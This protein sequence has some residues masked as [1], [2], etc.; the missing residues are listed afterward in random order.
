MTSSSC[1]TQETVATEVERQ[2]DPNIVL[3]DSDEYSGIYESTTMVIE[4]AKSL[5]AFYAKINRTRKP[6]LPVP[7]IDFSKNT[8]LVV[9]AGERKPN[10]KMVLSYGDEND[11]TLIINAE[12]YYPNVKED[13]QI[14]VI[15]NPFYL[16]TIPL[17]KKSVDLKMKD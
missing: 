10:S 3:V 12:S 13:V 4:D 8:A 7:Q 14:T 9:C 16:Y 17:S 1:K 6:G 2:S 5:N 15:T 11:N